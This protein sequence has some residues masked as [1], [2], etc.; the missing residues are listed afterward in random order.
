MGGGRGAVRVLSHAPLQPGIQLPMSTSMFEAFGKAKIDFPGGSEQRHPFGVSDTRE[1]GGHFSAGSGRVFPCNCIA[2]PLL[3]GVF[4]FIYLPSLESIWN[5]AN[6]CTSLYL[7]SFPHAQ[8]SFL[9]SPIALHDMQRSQGSYRICRSCVVKINVQAISYCWV[10][11]VSLRSQ[12][13]GSA[14]TYF[15][16]L[17]ARSSPVSL[18]G[19][20]VGLCGSRSLTD[21]RETLTL[22][23]G[24][25]LGSLQR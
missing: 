19:W 9:T 23:R 13:R 24:W 3:L 12:P 1:H 25:V 11:R 22:R 5:F 17:R 4:F 2:L 10:N 20:P 14:R 8:L 21:S 18:S 7:P 6:A 16:F 15:G